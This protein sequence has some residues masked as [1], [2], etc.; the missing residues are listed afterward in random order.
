MLEKIE[1]FLFENPRNAIVTIVLG[2]L[3]LKETSVLVS[4]VA[5]FFVAV[6]N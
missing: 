1:K 2:T 5:G 3:L 4:F 6:F